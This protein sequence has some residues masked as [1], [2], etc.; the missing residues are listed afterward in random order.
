MLP[1]VQTVSS[2]SIAFQDHRSDILPAKGADA[3]VPAVNPVVRSGQDLNPAIAA[4]LNILMLSGHEQ[5]AENVAVLADMV[6]QAIGVVRKSG[7]TNGA[8]AQRFVEALAKLTPQERVVLERLLTQTMTGVKLRLLTDAFRNP[9]GPEAAK[10]AVYLEIARHKERDLATRSV[11]TS[12]RQNGGDP[13]SVA[14]GQ[15][16]PSSRPQPAQPQPSAQMTS[17]SLSEQPGLSAGSASTWEVRASTA[18]RSG[19]GLPAADEALDLAPNAGGS[20]VEQAVGGQDR[21]DDAKPFRAMPDAISASSD[22]G[23]APDTAL[24]G[25]PEQAH[26]A[27]M[28]AGA[29][30]IDAVA[31]KSADPLPLEKGARALQERLRQTFEAGARSVAP[32]QVRVAGDGAMAA[33]RG[34]ALPSSAPGDGGED[35]AATA[36][37]T[38]VSATEAEKRGATA[39]LTERADRSS[40]TSDPVQTMFVLKG[41]KEVIS[42]T[43]AA[44]EAALSD[45]AASH[46]EA[47]DRKTEPSQST[48]TEIA[49]MSADMP[50]ADGP[51]NIESRPANQTAAP[52][53]ATVEAEE[54]EAAAAEDEHADHQGSVEPTSRDEELAALRTAMPREGIP[55]PI[56]NYLA[57][58]EFE[59]PTEPTG[60]K[61]KSDQDDESAEE[62]AADQQMADDGTMSDEGGDADE[63]EILSASGETADDEARIE[64]AVQEN[65]DAD[66]AND[67]YWRMAG[68]S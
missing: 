57:M 27:N 9:A 22:D 16:M 64:V 2:T 17:A 12:Y 39:T 41:W 31:R 30:L 11:V 59:E 52:S 65:A 23:T 32:D 63:E 33:A 49:D 15:Q 21:A 55:L 3:Q 66:R 68:W 8:F 60:S 35:S 7:E 67:L 36:R 10:L 50:S 44:I 61:Q 18:P 37:Q 19:D 40:R 29:D 56:V 28:E 47:V 54:D 48:A 34:A 13:K 38:D 4:R 58:Q 43:A 1:P 42:S 6:G 25:P 51:E 5:M 20:N 46:A 26:G 62:E 14:P 45:H 24:P 53:D